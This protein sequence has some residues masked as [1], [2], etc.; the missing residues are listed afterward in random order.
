MA[1]K[2]V[3]T[4]RAAHESWNKRDF[5]GVVK[6]A[7]D[8]TPTGNGACE[9]DLA[10]PHL[11]LSKWTGESVLLIAA[12]KL[13]S[14]FLRRAYEQ[15]YSVRRMQCGFDQSREWLLNPKQSNSNADQWRVLNE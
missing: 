13:C 4:L 15:S 11:L 3:E 10:I 14:L 1:S 12:G 5:A 8:L 9:P 7:V 6:N 2:N